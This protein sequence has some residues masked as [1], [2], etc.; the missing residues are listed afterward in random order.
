ME[1]TFSIITEGSFTPYDVLE[2]RSDNKP[3][4]IRERNRSVVQ[5]ARSTGYLLQAFEE[6]RSF[7]S[8]KARPTI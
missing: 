3:N 2:I 7:V 8:I 4:F 5:Y 6:N 1:V